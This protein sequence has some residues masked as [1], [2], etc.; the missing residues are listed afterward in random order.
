MR[1]DGRARPTGVWLGRP[2]RPFANVVF[3]RTQMGPHIEPAGWRE[4]HPGETR[5][6]DSASYAEYE[7]A[8]PG[9]H[10][11]ERDRHTKHLNAAK[12]GRYTGAQV[13]SGADGWNPSAIQ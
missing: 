2:W 9:A 13:L 12:A 1:I 11:G 3:L 10:P 6:L 7:S 4:W 5:Y 8:G